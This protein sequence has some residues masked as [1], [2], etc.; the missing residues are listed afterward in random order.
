MY[1][2]LSDLINHLLGTNI[3]LPVQTYG[4]FVALAFLAA[5]FT[6]Y[7]ELRRKEKAGIIHGQ[8]KEI[9]KGKPATWKEL[10]ITGMISFIIGFK[11]GGI[12]LE[13]GKFDQ[14]PSAYLFS[15]EGNVLTG[16][17]MAVAYIYLTWRRKKREALEKPRKVTVTI[18]PYQLTTNIILVAAI[19]G[20]I[21]SKIF[22]VVEHIDE[23]FRDPAGVLF[24]FS[25]LTFYGGLIVAAFAVGTYAE[26]NRIPWPVI[27][28]TVAPGLMLAYGTGRIGC[29]LSGDGCWGVVNTL[30]KPGWLSWLPDRMW[31]FNYP[32]NVINEGVPITG[33]EGDHCYVLAQAVFPTPIYETTV[34]YLLFLLL[35]SLR[36]KLRLPGTLFAIYLIVNGTARLF[37]EQIRVNIRYDFLGWQVTQAEMIAIGLITAGIS[38]IFFFRWWNKKRYDPARYEP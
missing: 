31:S 32:N 15:S 14:D 36:K 29:Q 21:G 8:K 7:L 27:A 18:H 33:C 37:I 34:A 22:D 10:A 20:L 4:F 9:T 24:S 2:K 5:G 13:Y 28:D 25:G 23:L 38:G 11:L 30:P 16:L 35:W 19:F 26:M 1:P 12:I 3:S 17:V 6:V